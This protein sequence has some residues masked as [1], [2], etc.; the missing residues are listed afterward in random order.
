MKKFINEISKEGDSMG[1]KYRTSCPRNC[2]S[3][4][5]LLVTVED[6]RV[7]KIEGDPL[8]LTT[9]QPCLKGL[10]YVEQVYSPERLVY[11][12]VRKGQRGGGQWEKVSWDQALEMIVD[13]LKVIRE[14]SGPEAVFYYAGSGSSGA[15]N[16]LA[17]AFWYQYGGYTGVY[18]DLCW[19]AGLEGERLVYGENR[20]S[21]PQDI[22]NS[23]LLILWGKNP[24]YTN[25]QETRW[26]L[27]AVESG[28]KLVVIDPFKNPLA[29]VADLFLQPR[30]GTDGLLAL[31]IIQELILDGG[32][33]REFVQNY[34]QG[35]S[36]LK[37]E[38][39][40]YS[41]AKGAEGTGI[42]AEQ[43]LALVD[44]F[45]E[46]K[47]ARIISGYG[48]Q[49][50]T[51]GGETV[52][53]MAL[54]PALTGNIGIPGGGWNYANLQSSFDL[55]IPLPPEPERIRLS[56]PVARM[57][58]GLHETTDPA[59]RMAW[60]EYGNPLVSNPNVN[61]LKAGFG[62]L[63]FIV[64]VDQFITD[65]A[66]QADL[67]LPAK[68]MFEQTDVVTSYW[69]SYIQIRD[70][71]IEPYAG[72]KT[73]PW[74]YRQLALRMGYD[75]RWIP[76]DTEE[77]LDKQLRTKGL[78]LEMLRQGP[79]YAP[80]A[81]PVV[82][83]DYQF[84]TPSGKIQ[85]VS[86][87]AEAIWGLTRVPHYRPPVESNGSDERYP[88]HLVTIHPRGRIHSQ[89][90]SNRWLNEISQGPRLKMNID[91]AILRSL[92][93]G[94]PIIIYNDRGKINASVEI[95]WGLNSGVV[96][97]EEGWWLREGGSVDV[98][99]EDR[100]TDLGYGTAFHDCLV[101]VRK[102]G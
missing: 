62:K 27:D 33:D 4:C 36:E 52:R 81:N 72:I 76:E 91:D 79:V 40:A 25:I 55:E 16:K 38:I 47:P 12:L 101:E 49:R 10:S 92:K 17:K 90:R 50:Y 67:I 41:L 34:C 7:T 80:W 69:H 70:K 48:L 44:L 31:T 3:T 83:C 85:L 26:I 45:R 89:F 98:L 59:L 84:E 95:S 82:Y 57:A 24:S 87:E 64:V 14:V 22:L 58:S 66:A 73:E 2:Y 42:L 93:N 39:G 60:I 6:G 51:N 37:A 30:P 74:I 56:I 54:I 43:I 15:L 8:Q 28:T 1:K 75:G 35:F 5:S 9:R 21:D 99:S 53:A 68:S 13:K 18:G 29:E 77:L 23:K 100:I 20:H 86:S 94:D 32:Y 78:S 46:I 71:L 102:D 11:P 96:V 63:E 97:I 88:L 65:T 61:K 19:S